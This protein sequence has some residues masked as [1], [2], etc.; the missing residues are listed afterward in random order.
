MKDVSKLLAGYWIVLGMKS[1][2]KVIPR[3]KLLV[4]D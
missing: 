3:K 4:G 2:E 1:G